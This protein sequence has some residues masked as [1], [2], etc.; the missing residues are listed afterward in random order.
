MPR[1]SVCDT[2]AIEAEQAHAARCAT[3]AMAKEGASTH[4]YGGDLDKPG[5][6][7]LK[8]IEKNDKLHRLIKEQRAA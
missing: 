7:L 5:G 8:E 2:E 1:M 4:K 6:I 3:R